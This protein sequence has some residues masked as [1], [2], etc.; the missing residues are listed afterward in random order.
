[1]NWILQKVKDCIGRTYAILKW[2]VFMRYL[3]PIYHF[4]VMEREKDYVM[5]YVNEDFD[6]TSDEII[7]QTKLTKGEAEFTNDFHKDVKTGMYYFTLK[8]YK[9]MFKDE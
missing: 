1:M 6:P 2:R 5:L 3:Y 7:N 4:F 9:K 8:E